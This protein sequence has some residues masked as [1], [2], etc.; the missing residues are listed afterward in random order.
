MFLLNLFKFVVLSVVLLL[1]CKI[2]SS[3][4]FGLAGAIVVQILTDSSTFAFV[5][6]LISL[7]LAFLRLIW[8]YTFKGLVV[9]NLF[10][11]ALFFL[12]KLYVSISAA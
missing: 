3:I 1:V 10:L 7:S 5:F 9:I 6:V 4:L 11:I 12:F 8:S 2:I